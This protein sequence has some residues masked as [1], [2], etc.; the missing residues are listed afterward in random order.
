[1]MSRNEMITLKLQMGIDPSAHIEPNV[2]LSMW[3]QLQLETARNQSDL[4]E[5]T[6]Y[7]NQMA[8]TPMLV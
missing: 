7:P 4:S 6:T 1:M 8:C 5:T 3:Q 2:L